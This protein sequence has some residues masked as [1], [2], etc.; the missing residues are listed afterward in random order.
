MDFNDISNRHRKLLGT[1]IEVA[2]L[3]KNGEELVELSISPVR[4]DKS[5]LFV[6]RLPRN[7]QQTNEAANLLTMRSDV[8]GDCRDP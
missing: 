2:E 3:R 8:I 6:G 5:I 1:R 7:A 4:D